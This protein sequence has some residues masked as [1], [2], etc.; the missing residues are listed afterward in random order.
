MPDELSETAPMPKQ[1]PTADRL[2]QD[3]P[4]SR[5]EKL[6]TVSGP[7]TAGQCWIWRGNVGS[8]GY[9]RVFWKGRSFPAHRFAYETFVGPI[10]RGMLACHK[11]DVPLCI[12]PDRIF[13]GSIADNNRDMAIKGRQAKPKLNPEAVL[14]SRTGKISDCELA[15]QMGCSSETV[16]AARLRITWKHV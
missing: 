1:L 15:R 8:N 9:G 13:L 14:L 3:A 4:A 12:N 11:C 5:V 2:T 16:R 7:L 6:L 10:G